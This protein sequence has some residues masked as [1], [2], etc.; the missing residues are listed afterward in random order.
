MTSDHYTTWCQKWNP[1]S[2]AKTINGTVMITAARSL[3]LQELRRVTAMERRFEQFRSASGL[4]DYP[5]QRQVSTLF[6]C[7]EET[8]EDVSRS[9][10]ID[11]DERKKYDRSS[12]I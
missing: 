12:Q 2:Q 6:Y 4:S 7:L 8:A 5:E 11:V 9:T 1:S 3:Q 10:H